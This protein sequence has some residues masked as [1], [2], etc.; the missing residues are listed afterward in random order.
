MWHRDACYPGNLHIGDVVVAGF[1][2]QEV[3]CIELYKLLPFLIWD[4]KHFWPWDA[5]STAVVGIP[6]KWNIAFFGKYMLPT[7][8]LGLT[9]PILEDMFGEMVSGCRVF[10]AIY[11]LQLSVL[12]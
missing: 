6:D 5:A 8:F 1:A 3:A 11:E 4:H 2:E 9:E 7:F 12:A 10:A